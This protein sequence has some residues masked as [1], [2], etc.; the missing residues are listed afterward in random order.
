MFFFIFK[1]ELCKC[2]HNMFFRIV[3]A[4]VVVVYSSLLYITIQA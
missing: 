4:V 2:T 3:C 1:I